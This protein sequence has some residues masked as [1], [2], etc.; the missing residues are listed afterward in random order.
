MQWS[1]TRNGGFSTAPSDRLRL[2]AIEHGEYGWRSVN[3]EAQRHDP[4]SLLNWVERATRRRKECPAFG[5]GACRFVEV[6]DARV[7]AHRCDDA[8]T[9]VYAVHN[10][11]D[12]AVRIDLPVNPDGPGNDD[13]VVHDVLS[14]RRDEVQVDGHYHLELEPFGYRWLMRRGARR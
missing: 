14:G 9:T 12:A 11:S 7:L 13:D 2:P 1:A 4:D 3:V 8:D 5:L 10:L 6:G